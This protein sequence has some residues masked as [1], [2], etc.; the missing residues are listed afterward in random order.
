MHRRLIAIL[1]LTCCLPALAELRPESARG[2]D[3]TGSWVLNQA[4]SD[5]PERM[6][7]ERLDKERRRFEQWRRDL[8]RTRPPEQPEDLENERPPPAAAQPG[9]GPRPWQVRQQENFRKM[10]AISDTL[11]ITQSGAKIDIVSEVESRR[12]EAGTN[13]QVSMPEGQ[14]ADS[15]VGW[16]GEW[17]VIDR[18]VK[19]GPRAVEKFRLVPKTGQL[20]YLMNWSGDS[21]LAGIKVRRLYDRGVATPPPADP[22]RG[23]VR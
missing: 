5:D 1:L 16:D 9:R 2:T 10:L 20:E 22:A 11:N 19:R 14:L 4:A 12:L 7:N 21:E 6:L 23:P 15:S 3:L 8:E 17:F 13:T 18:R